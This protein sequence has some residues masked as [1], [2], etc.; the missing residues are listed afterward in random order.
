VWLV[1]ANAWVLW[2][3]V[4][5][6]GVGG[7]AAEALCR[8]GVGHLTLVDLDAVCVSNTNR[9]VHALAATVGQPKTAVLKARLQAINPAVAVHEVGSCFVPFWLSIARSPSDF[10]R[11]LKG[12]WQGPVERFFYCCFLY[13]LVVC[14]FVV[15]S[16][17]YYCMSA[18]ASETSRER[19]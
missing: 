18:M 4:G 12:R 5:V 16:F 9:Q 10:T 6:G 17:C 14:C 13:G 2:Q 8:S 1:G 15:Y 11:C 3:V 19:V 7:W